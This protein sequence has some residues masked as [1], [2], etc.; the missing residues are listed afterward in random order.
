MAP[1]IQLSEDDQ[2]EIISFLKQGFKAYCPSSSSIHY[3]E[4]LWNSYRKR[5]NPCEIFPDHLVSKIDELKE[6]IPVAD[7]LAKQPLVRKYLE[8]VGVI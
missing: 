2:K 5:K 6:N 3:R 7:Y 8:N 1:E 4:S